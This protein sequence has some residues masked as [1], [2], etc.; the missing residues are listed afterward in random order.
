MY[1]GSVVVVV[2]GGGGPPAPNTARPELFTFVNLA[3]PELLPFINFTGI[4]ILLWCIW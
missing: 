2:V 1:T 3:R 4:T